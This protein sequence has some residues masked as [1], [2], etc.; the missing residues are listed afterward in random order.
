MKNI[1]TL[2]LFTQGVYGQNSN[3]LMLNYIQ[4][5]PQSTLLQRPITVKDIE[6]MPVR[7]LAST[8]DDSS[9]LIIP[10]KIS[11]IA[12]V[13]TPAA[14]HLLVEPFNLP[15]YGFYNLPAVHNGT[16]TVFIAPAY[17]LQSKK[18]RT[19]YDKWQVSV[20]SKVG[21]AYF[22][23]PY[24]TFPRGPAAVPTY[25]MDT[26][27]IDS[28]RVTIQGIVINL[29]SADLSV[30]TASGIMKTLPPAVAH[31]LWILTPTTKSPQSFAGFSMLSLGDAE[32][33]SSWMRQGL[34]GAPV[35]AENDRSVLLGIVYDTYLAAG[36][37]YAIISPIPHNEIVG[38]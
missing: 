35:A 38:N 3:G 9:T 31:A 23:T 8:T 4:Q 7:I 28:I 17:T 29:D 11:T 36:K 5:L 19:L 18:P 15:A 21:L 12:A 10:N 27:S 16:D 2:I 20:K 6:T 13:V 14:K 32:K 37:I 30:I 26:A 34:L 22:R 33:L 1:I 24:A 25:K